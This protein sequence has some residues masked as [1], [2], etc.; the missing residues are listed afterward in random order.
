VLDTPA[1]VVEVRFV[2][3]SPET[4]DAFDRALGR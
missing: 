2:L 4:Y 1:A 3:F